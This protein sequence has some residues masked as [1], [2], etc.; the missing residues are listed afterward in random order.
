MKNILL[1]LAL[2][3]STYTQCQEL[4]WKSYTDPNGEQTYA[5]SFYSDGSIYTQGIEYT[6]LRDPKHMDLLDGISGIRKL[7]DD[8]KMVQKKKQPISTDLYT[9]E[10]GSFGS[11]TLK[12]T[13]VPRTYTFTKY[14]IKLFE[15]ELKK[16][17]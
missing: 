15:K 5:I 6:Y 4:V 3:V 13:N 7:V 12:I 8:I 17:E 1:I 10:K 11:A 9:I 16:F 2:I 14:A